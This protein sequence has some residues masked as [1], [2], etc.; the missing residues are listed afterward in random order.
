VGTLYN[1]KDAG[2]N[3]T[4][5][6]EAGATRS[7]AEGRLYVRRKLRRGIEDERSVIEFG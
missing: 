6:L 1:N 5:Q 4:G 2:E 3:R 7:R